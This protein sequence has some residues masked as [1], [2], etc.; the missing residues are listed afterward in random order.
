[1]ER[2]LR[3][4]AGVSLRGASLD[5]PRSWRTVLLAIAALASLHLITYWLAT[6]IAQARG[7]AAVRSLALPLDRRIPYLSWS[8]PVYWLPYLLIP[9]GAAGVLRR[10]DP[11]AF[12]RMLTAY[13]GLML[14]GAAIQ[15]AVPSLAP[16]P[17]RP[18]PT[19]QVFHASALVLPYAAFPSMHVA[20]TTLTAVIVTSVWRRPG[21]GLT[22]GVIVLLVALAT[23][24]LREHVLLDAGAGVL[25]GLASGWWWRHGP[26]PVV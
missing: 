24:T 20:L 21:V 11:T 16:W 9:L 13:G 19:Q 14:A 7:P 23:L 22:A 3:S 5:P 10:L 17:A 6:R 12:R 8:W 15:A 26:G 4:K 18:A 2:A 25:L 1:M